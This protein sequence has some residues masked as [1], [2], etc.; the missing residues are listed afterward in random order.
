[1][2]DKQIDIIGVGS[3]IMDIL[4]RVDEAFIAGIEGGK[5]GMLLVDDKQMNALLD[6]IEEPPENAPG[7][8]AG[9][10]VF[11]LAKL[12]L[13]VAMLGKIGNDPTAELY[14][15]TLET[16]GGDTT[17]FKKAD[18]P[19]GVCLSLITP[20]S[21]RT[22]RT[23]LGAAMTLTP[24]EVSEADFANCKHAHIEGYLLFNRELMVKVLE[25][26]KGAGCSISLDLASYETVHATEDILEDLIRNY[27]DI[28]IA[29]EEEAAA[30]HGKDMSYEDMAC[31]FAEIAEIAIVKLG[32]DGSIIVKGSELYRVK[33]HI[34]SNLVDTTGAGDFWAAGVLYG[35]SKGYNLERCGELG[36]ILGAEVVQVTGADLPDEQWKPILPIF[37]SANS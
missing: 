2:A 21:E 22:M 4:T 10:T 20:D 34:V 5:G 6:K 37:E 8:S 31:K 13:S 26:A 23:N 1:M 27:V 19:N 25:S 24:E 9:N 35:W 3:P 18:I 11:A 16:L 7:G 28:I 14:K 15:T 33:P 36:S 30:Y 32:K 29:N 12:G 17:H